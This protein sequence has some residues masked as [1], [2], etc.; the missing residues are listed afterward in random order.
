MK[1]LKKNIVFNVIYDAF[2]LIFPLIT[3]M[4]VARILLPSGVGT[5][6]YAQNISSY[7]VT[8]AALGLPTYG[9]RE[10][11]KVQKEKNALNKTYTELFIIN[12]VTT[13][14][15]VI[16]YIILLMTPWG[17]TLDRPL[18]LCFGVSIL[19]NYISIDWMYKGN[20]EYVYITIRSIVIKI[21]SLALVLIFVKTREDYLKYAAI[22]V[23]G[24]GG[25][26]VFN[27]IHSRKLVKF[28]FKNLEFKKH[29]TPLLVLALSLFLSTIYSRIDI[30][31]LGSMSTK[32]ATGLYTNAHKITDMIITACS[33]IS[34]VFL[35]RLSYYY[36]N[37]P[38][39]FTQLIET[40]V[41]VLS[42]ISIPAGVGLFV[43]A[44]QALE[45]MFGKEF[46]SGAPTVRILS[47][48]IIV[49]SFGNLLCYQLVIC[50][51]NEKKRLPAYALAN[52]ANIGLNALLIPSLSHSGAAIASVASELIVNVYQFIKMRKIIHIP[53]PKKS[54][55]QAVIS[56]A[57]MGAVV[58]FASKLFSSLLL[59]VAAGV[60]LGF[61]VY[62]ALNLIMKN[63]FLLSTISML[64]SKIKG[65]K[66]NDGE[67]EE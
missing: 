4:Y 54:I 9:I 42:F 2:N 45:L 57:V 10:I 26:Y 27:I 51:G 66:I 46:V 18:M 41:R 43:L 25:N 16:G 67:T 52:V 14:A 49:K 3:S 33:A 29:L 11:A 21:I 50:T 17:K 47:S 63:E 59:N 56:S 7:F 62:I 32:E 38:E 36:K 19:F 39:K 61:A 5:V 53:I 35:P 58:F 23:I 6:S 28:S 34:A 44:P 15:A 12:A 8:L 48:L 24:L 22:I 64:T 55:V 13:T 30:T 60:L 31:M 40:G 20:E 65:A 1:S 37:E